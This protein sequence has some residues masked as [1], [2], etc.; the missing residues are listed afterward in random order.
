MAWILRNI[1]S[2]NIWLVSDLI[3]FTTKQKSEGIAVFIAFDSLEWDF[4]FKTLDTF[5][6]GCD[7]KTWIKILYTSPWLHN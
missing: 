4:L 7:L 2:E 1:I 5:R 3:H 6:F